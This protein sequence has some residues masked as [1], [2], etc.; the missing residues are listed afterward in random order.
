[1]RYLLLGFLMF[2]CV[3]PTRTTVLFSAAS[4]ETKILEF[5]QNILSDDCNGVLG[6]CFKP[7]AEFAKL[8]LNLGSK[9]RD[10]I[11]AESLSDYRVRCAPSV[12]DS[13]AP[14]EWVIGMIDSNESKELCQ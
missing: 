11:L 2:G 7:H 12:G 8:D 9:C 3:E 5:E 10:I 4:C 14:S 1:M 13:R 6:K